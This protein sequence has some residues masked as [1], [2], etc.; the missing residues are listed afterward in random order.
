MTKKEATSEE[1]LFELVQKVNR[2]MST[3]MKSM[4]KATQA[5]P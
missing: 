3:L 1:R 4:T 2:K 5:K